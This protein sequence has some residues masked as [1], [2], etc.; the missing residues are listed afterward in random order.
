MSSISFGPLVTIVVGA[1]LVLLLIYTGACAA[2]ALA[3]PAER[4]RGSH[5]GLGLVA[6][7]SGLIAASYVDLWVL[8][9]W[10][11]LAALCLLTFAFVP[12]KIA[13]LG[14]S[15]G[16]ML[17]EAAALVLALAMM[18]A[19]DPPAVEH[20]GALVMIGIVV[21]IQFVALLVNF[22]LLRKGR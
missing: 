18:G 21:L 8:Q 12:Y 22:G 19:K 13:T 17:A 1:M 15:G 16:L 11:A 2:Y 5:A 4:C 6:L 20:V 7:G 3:R 14:A 9:A 10:S